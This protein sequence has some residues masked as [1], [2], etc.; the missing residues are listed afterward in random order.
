MQLDPSNNPCCGWFV[1]RSIIIALALLSAVLLFALFGNLL[2]EH[3]FDKSNLLNRNKPPVFVGGS[4]DYPLGTDR[5][6]RDMV[7]RLAYGTRVSIGLAFLG[8]VIGLLLG[9]VL[10][11]LAARAHAL[12]DGLIMALIDLQ[13]AIPFMIIALATLAIFGSSLMLFLVILGGVW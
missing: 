11:L 1:N 7:A 2:T 6:G 10:G 8:T 3:S 4:W 13:A 12:A 9:T 5:L